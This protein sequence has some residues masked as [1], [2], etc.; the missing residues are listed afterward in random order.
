MQVEGCQQHWAQQSLWQEEWFEG[1][2][3][4]VG[5]GFGSGLETRCLE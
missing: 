4:G 3:W 1:L 5:E 2:G